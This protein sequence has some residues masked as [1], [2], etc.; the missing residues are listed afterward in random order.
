MSWEINKEDKEQTADEALKEFADTLGGGQRA[1]DIASAMRRQKGR[2][3]ELLNESLD[4]LIERAK[5][6]L[7]DKATIEEGGLAGV[8]HTIGQIYEMD[9]DTSGGSTSVNNEKTFAAVEALLNKVL[10]D[11]V[12][13]ET[14]EII[15]NGKAE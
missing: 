4:E 13:Q 5:N 2:A 11:K 10:K 8:V 3:L 7:G 12:I 6:G 15:I 9:R 1:M 14:K